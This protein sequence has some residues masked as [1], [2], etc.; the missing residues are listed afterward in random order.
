MAHKT[1]LPDRVAGELA[2]LTGRT[3]AEMKLVLGVG[4]VVSAVTLVATVVYKT[5]ELAIDMDIFDH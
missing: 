4:A 3:D 5:V 2:D 1:N